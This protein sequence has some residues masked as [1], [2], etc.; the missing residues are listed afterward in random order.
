MKK[1][2]KT[3]TKSA[4]KKHFTLFGIIVFLLG[5]IIFF[6]SFNTSLAYTSAF[7]ALLGALF[8]AISILFPGQGNEDFFVFM[9][10][11]KRMKFNALFVMLIDL[12]FILAMYLLFRSWDIVV[13]FTAENF[14]GVFFYIILI[15]LIISLI[16]LFLMLW[17]LFQGFNWT[18]I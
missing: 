13:S 6:Y 5:L 3:I 18:V 8:F 16:A 7:I 15:L 4:E 14:G 9:D 2:R 1:K 12:M 11:F 17:A 10:S